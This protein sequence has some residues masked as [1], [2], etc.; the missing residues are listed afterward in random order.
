VPTYHSFVP[1][2]RDIEILI[3]VGECGLL[4][5]QDIWE[6]WWPGC[7]L[8]PCQMRLRVLCTEG[9]LQKTPL[10]AAHAEKHGGRLPTIYTLTESGADLVEVHTGVRPPRVLNCSSQPMT[11]F[12]RLETVKFRRSVDAGY[13]RLGL[14]S[15]AWI[16]EQDTLPSDDAT[17]PLS[18][19][20]I[21]YERFELP[22]G[23]VSYR[24]DA[25][26]H[27]CV[28]TTHGGFTNLLAYIELDRSTMSLRQMARKWIGMN[29]F[30][31]NAA[32][33]RHWPT[34]ETPAV[35]VLFVCPSQ[36]RIE[37]LRRSVK[38]EWVADRIR[39][40]V[41]DA[42]LDPQQV[43]TAPIWHRVDDDQPPRPI[44]VS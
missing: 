15:P 2:L 16:M 36:K 41:R 39:F 42:A 27:L 5:T 18:N 13:E 26:V 35:R 4:D 32:Y 31:Q 33:S 9:L 7:L 29:A 14:P 24:A 19:R 10:V 6:Q 40:A 44:I 8:R 37:N 21:L 22:T 11:F 17:A 30:F 20:F 38:G 28:P 3:A 43:V 23:R 25:S 34:V 12:H 1:T